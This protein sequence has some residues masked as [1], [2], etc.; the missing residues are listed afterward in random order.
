M[1]VNPKT[2]KKFTR[3]TSVHSLIQWWNQKGEYIQFFGQLRWKYT[4]DPT[5]ITG[6]KCFSLSDSQGDRRGWLVSFVWGGLTSLVS[7]WQNTHHI[8]VVLPQRCIFKRFLQQFSSGNQK[9]LLSGV[10]TA[11]LHGHRAA[12]H[13]SI[14]GKWLISAGQQGFC[15]YTGFWGC[16]YLIHFVSYFLFSLGNPNKWKVSC[17]GA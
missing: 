2:L 7:S 13:R 10:P 6:V 12:W 14:S 5:G 1:E 8:M 9:P 15:F 16:F 4:A 17:S 3:R 11:L